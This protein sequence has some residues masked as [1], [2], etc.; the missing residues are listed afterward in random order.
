M[1]QPHDDDHTTNYVD[2][3]GLLADAVFLTGCEPD[4]VEPAASS[5]PKPNHP[6]H[7]ADPMAPVTDLASDAVLLKA[8]ESLRPE[9]QP[10]GDSLLQTRFGPIKPSG[11]HKRTYPDSDK[12][13]YRLYID[14]VRQDLT[15]TELI[16][17]VKPG[18]PVWGYTRHYQPVREWL[19]NTTDLRL[20]TFSGI[21][22]TRRLHGKTSTNMV[23]D[24][25]MPVNHYT[26]TPNGQC[27]QDPG[28]P[29]GDFGE[30]P[31]PGDGE[32]TPDPGDGA[33]A[34]GV[35]DGCIR[36]EAPSVI[37]GKTNV[38]EDCGGG[39][40]FMYTYTSVCD[41]YLD[42]DAGGGG[43]GDGS[44]SDP[45][46]PPNNE[47]DPEGLRMAVL[48]SRLEDDPFALIENCDQIELWKT[49]AQHTPSNH[50]IEK[51]KDL[52]DNHE[53]PFGNWNIQYLDDANGTIVNLDYWPVK[54]Q[55]LPKKASGIRYTP[56]EF[57]DYFR[58]N[59]NEFVV[60][61]PFEPYSELSDSL[62]I[63]ENTL[64]YSDDP[65]GALVKIDI[66]P[67]DGVVI[68]SEKEN[69]SWK[70]MTLEA[71]ID[72]NHPVSGTREFGIIE[73]EDNTYTLY[74]R[75]VDRFT[76][77]SQENIAFMIDLVTTGFPSPFQGADDFWKPLQMGVVNFVKDNGGQAV[78]GT[79]IKERPDWDKIKEVLEG[80]R[81]VSDIGC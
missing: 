53:G 10:A 67:N 42:P 64:W 56:K 47:Y 57:I 22:T 37:P 66:A 17:T 1:A 18:Q 55:S 52:Q 26:V 34:P 63:Q 38:W 39:A 27:E 46:T 76:S 7:Q 11:I 44:G 49:L 4:A 33:P 9:A 74:T 20:Q 54:I 28:E 50:V 21:V 16:L 68:C 29:I 69:Y 5:A 77:N 62:R 48:E 45:V 15:W 3:G 23:L 8:L 75:G 71:P 70:F 36:Y 13:T 58:K 6:V 35:G 43:S 51:I 32:G 24:Y 31:T 72:M 79:V 78:E 41:D 19:Y 65:I 73:N 81:P 80:S 60:G 30:Y 12:V 40:R 59:L 2:G 25:G 14:N 61:E